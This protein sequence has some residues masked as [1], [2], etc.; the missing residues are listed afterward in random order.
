MSREF[1]SGEFESGEFES[2]EFNIKNKIVH[3]SNAVDMKHCIGHTYI[4]S[5][6]P[7]S[8]IYW[9]QLINK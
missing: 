8:N 4:E 5:I 1:E 2:G 3:I 6:L 7:P 9:N